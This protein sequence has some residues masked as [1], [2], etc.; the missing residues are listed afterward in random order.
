MQNVGNDFVISTRQYTKKLEPFTLDSV[1]KNLSEKSPVFYMVL[2]NL[3]KTIILLYFVNNRLT[4]GLQVL[5]TDSI[6]RSRIY[7]NL[8]DLTLTMRLDY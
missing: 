4:G 2:D 8:A 6:V 7:S 1:A 3:R 5:S